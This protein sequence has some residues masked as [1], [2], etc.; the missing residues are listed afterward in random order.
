MNDNV[1]TVE[2]QLLPTV[3]DLERE[4]KHAKVT[5][6]EFESEANKKRRQAIILIVV[7]SLLLLLAVGLFLYFYLK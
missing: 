1:D 4:A 5:A 6:N 2:E 7:I 3:L